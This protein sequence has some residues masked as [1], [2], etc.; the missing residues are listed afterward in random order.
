MISS[1]LACFVFALF[2]AFLGAG[3]SMT[4]MSSSLVGFDAFLAGFAFGFA[5][6]FFLWNLMGV[7]PVSSDV[8]DRVF[9]NGPALAG[10]VARNTEPTS[11]RMAARCMA[12]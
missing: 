2:A 11:N 9:P 6:F 12:W 3:S 10:C 7:V 5:A 8:S 1:S 4:M